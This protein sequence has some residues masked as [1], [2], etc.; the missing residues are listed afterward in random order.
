MKTHHI[1]I[2]GASLLAAGCSKPTIA[3]NPAD[4]RLAADMNII[5]NVI[6]KQP[7]YKKAEMGEL[8]SHP[9]IPITIGTNSDQRHYL[10]T[11]NGA[12]WQVAPTNQ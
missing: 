11:W 12:K 6:I 4:S 10:L 9:T 5:T 3:S 1:L 7:L 2:I 8:G